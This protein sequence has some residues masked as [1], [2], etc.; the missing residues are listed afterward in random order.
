M[1]YCYTIISCVLTG[2]TSEI[3]NINTLVLETPFQ[4]TLEN[5]KLFTCDDE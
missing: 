3:L 2:Q 5:I 4:N 1:H